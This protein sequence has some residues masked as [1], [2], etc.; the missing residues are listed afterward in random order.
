M[1]AP[2]SPPPEGLESVSHFACHFTLA[3]VEFPIVLMEDHHAA[4]RIAS[5]GREQVSRN[6]ITFESSVPDPFAKEPIEF[7]DVASLGF[8]RNRVRK[9]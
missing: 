9:S 6:E 5:P 7:L 8:H 1:T 3:K 2:H 4:E